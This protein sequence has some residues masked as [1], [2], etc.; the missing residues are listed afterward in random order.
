MPSHLLGRKRVTA[1]KTRTVIRL[2]EVLLSS[3]TELRKR[4]AN[5][6]Q[7]KRSS[8]VESSIPLTRAHVQQE[9][10]QRGAG[11][12]GEGVLAEAAA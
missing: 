8:R 10:G 9:L 7:V 3:I 1:W 11:G 5:P 12:C 6:L 4:N 2:L